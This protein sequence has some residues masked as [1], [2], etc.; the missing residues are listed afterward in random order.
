MPETVELF[1]QDRVIGIFRGFSEGGLEF[2]ADLVLPYRTEFHNVPMHGQFLLVRLESEDEA[3]LGRITSLS[4]EGRLTASSGEDFTIRAIR[5]RRSVSEQLREDYLKYRVNIRVLGVLR[6]GADGTLTFVASHR[7]LPHVG[8]PVAFLSDRVLRE[9]AGH[10]VEGAPIGYLAMG[11][12]IYAD[13]EDALEVLPW[14]Q[15]K[16]PAV[17]VKFTVDSLISRR[18]FVFARAGFGKSNLN[19][20]LF[21]NLYHETPTVEKR[22][23]RRV[24]VGTVIFDPDGEYFWPDDKGRPGLC[25]VPDLQ[26][27]IVVFTSRQA[28]S[29]YYGSFIAGG[30]KL[31]I[32]RFRPA[33][34]VA[35]TLS[36]ERQDQQNVAKIKGLDPGRWGELVDLID[37]EGNGADVDQ[38][39]E[40]LRLDD[41][42]DYEALAARSNMTRIVE[43]IH[44][45]TSQLMDMLLDALAAGKL[46][47]VDVSQLR[48]G[49]ALSLSGVILRRIFDHNQEQFTSAQPKTVPTIAVVEEAQAVLNERAPAARPYIEWVKEGRKYDLG[50]LLITQQPGA[51]PTEILSQGD[52][53]FIF[54]LLSSSDLRNVQAANS[55]FSGDLLSSLLNEPIIGQGVFWSSVKGT[56]YPIPLRVLSFEHIY[57]RQDQN[58][59]RGAVR[60]YATVLRQKHAAQVADAE[61]PVSAVSQSTGGGLLPSSATLVADDG[62]APLDQPVDALRLAQHRAIEALRANRVFRGKLDAG[63]IK[64]GHVSKLLEAELPETM[65][66]RSQIA[67]A[68]VKPALES[69]LGPE[70]EKWRTEKR[71]GSTFVVRV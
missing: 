40:L 4:S 32:R 31:D 27:K 52:N 65:S 11:E 56:P 20:L 17:V 71:N 28:P 68:L 26:D 59:T 42:Q 15:I 45:R 61:A 36:A 10:N 34:I 62:T 50:A 49:P 14:M 35:L 6:R 60:T 12:Y 22:G 33:D 48:G 30:I 44:D 69:L 18:T 1:P 55:H 13:G 23:G 58:Y 19:K 66:D 67:Y 57:K 24:P 5:E 63:G 8:S 38:I 43:M 2:H 54:H 37:D 70:N 21:S 25:D 41:R 39:R 3:V 7:R 16:S 64:W 47:I 51:I 9:I 46:C 53:W 29:P